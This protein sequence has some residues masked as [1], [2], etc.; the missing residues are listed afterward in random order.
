MVYDFSSRLLLGYLGCFLRCIA[1]AFGVVYH[2]WRVCRL[3]GCRRQR[4]R[5]PLFSS[6]VVY[7]YT[8][9]YKVPAGLS[10]ALHQHLSLSLTTWLGQMIQGMALTALVPW[11]YAEDGYGWFGEVDGRL[12]LG[13]GR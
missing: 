10:Q 7:I 1:S 3:C 9:F 5:K 4:C 13:T 6:L 12:Y 2:G 8:V 11:A